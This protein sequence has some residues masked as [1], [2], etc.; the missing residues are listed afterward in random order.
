MQLQCAHIY[1]RRYVNTRWDLENSLC[2]CARCHRWGHDKPLDFA[3]WV[4][5]YIGGDI[6]DQLRQRANSLKYKYDYQAK[7][8]ELKD[9]WERMQ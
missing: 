1:S 5:D 9:I 2:L 4:E 3:R 8:D 6:A 7:L